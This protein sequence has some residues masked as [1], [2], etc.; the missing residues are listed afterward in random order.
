MSRQAPGQG[1][2]VLIFPDRGAAAD[3][4]AQR[5]AESCARAVDRRGECAVALSGG[6]TPRD[7]YARLVEDPLRH[8][9]AWDRL[10][11]F[12]GDERGVPP[13]DPRSNF[14]MAQQTLLASVPIPS[15]RIYRMPAEQADGAAAAEAY[16]ALLRAHT[17]AA[18]DGWPQ[19]DLVLLGLGEDAHTASLFPHSPVLREAHRS[20][21]VYE[22]PRLGMAR[23]TLTPPVLNHAAEVIFLVAGEGKAPALRMVLEGPHDPDRVPAQLVRPISG[24]PAW[25][26]DAAAASQLTRPS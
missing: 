10:Q 19:L 16:E 25:F 3:A 4:A 18:P 15:D 12:W 5:V 2:E 17:P 23:M 20:V 7:L 13:T 14:R 6:D 11:V 9:I 21:V 1:P 24:G 8:R 22:V 26:V